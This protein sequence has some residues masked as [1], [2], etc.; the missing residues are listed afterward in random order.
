MWFWKHNWSRCG[1]SIY[2]TPLLI[3]A[4]LLLSPLSAVAQ[5]TAPSFHFDFGTSRSPV[6]SGYKRVTASS[7]ST[8]KDFGWQSTKGLS[9]A[10]RKLGDA[11]H[12]DLNLG[13]DHTFLVNLPNGS[14]SIIPTVGD[15]SYVRDNVSIWAEGKEALGNLS[16][17]KGQFGAPSFI[18]IV[19]DGQLTLRIVDSGGANSKFAIAALDIEALQD[20][21]PTPTPSPMPTATPKPTA[22]PSPLPTA[23][24]KPSPT[25]NPTVAPTSVPPPT[26]DAGA[27]QNAN[28]GD[29]VS[30]SGSASGGI[31]PFSYSW[32]F[33][34][35]GTAAG[36]LTATHKY[37]D[38]GS[39]AV[40]LK[41]TE[42]SGRTTT[43][44]ALVSVSNVP[45][46]P[47]TGGPYSG[48]AGSTISFIGGA[49]DPS[50]TDTAAGVTYLWDFGDGAKANLRTVSRAYS[51]AGTYTVTLTAKDKDGGSQSVSTTATVAVSQ[52]L[53]SI[54]L[55]PDKVTLDALAAQQFTATAKDQ[56]GNALT[57]QPAYTWTLYGD[58]TLSSSGLYTA[59]ASLGAATIRV[60]AGN[61]SAMAWVALHSTLAPGIHF[62]AATG[63]LIIQG[64]TYNDT[65][66]VQPTPVNGVLMANVTFNVS[67]A[68]GNLLQFQ[69][70]MI[71]LES[72]T[73]IYFYGQTGIDE[74]FT[75][76]SAVA[77]TTYGGA[78]TS[79]FQGVSGNDY[80]YAGYGSSNRLQG[81]DGDDLLVGG[82]GATWLYGGAGSDTL[83][84]G[85]G[86]GKNFLYPDL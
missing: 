81:M 68:L 46:I 12:R 76:N 71:V 16:T 29:L 44:S 47:I 35:G 86:P 39:Y 20:P 7:F 58:G 30:F 3:A 53:T 5:S 28:E 43:D 40:T 64:I 67:D 19:A 9:S 38:N 55:S 51:S 34:D 52:T 83:I 21:T 4:A 49:T 77:C 10:E 75:N 26:V 31:A 50:S 59:P 65:A 13:S 70:Q 57:S 22:T 54:V 11:L 33:G 32:D 85:P 37:A 48:T 42:S 2:A 24:P 6:E 15:T 25:A 23:T 62:D 41:V 18:A 74:F 69:N 45:P 78:G 61:V 27:D 66:G 72:I 82:I 17:A 56:F 79:T 14:Y 80:L 73:H 84:A 63:I 60:S 1:E 36:S 8:T